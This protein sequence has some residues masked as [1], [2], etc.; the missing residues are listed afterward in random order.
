MSDR[1]IDESTPAGG[2]WRTTGPSSE[3]PAEPAP[4]DPE[5]A[6]S[7]SELWRTVGTRDTASWQRVSEREQQPEPE[8][9]AEAEPRP[10]AAGIWRRPDGST[11]APVAEEPET[12]AAEAAQAE[13]ETDEAAEAVDEE[14]PAGVL[15]FEQDEDDED[16][17]SFSMS[18]LVALA[19]LADAA[20][21]VP[22]EDAPPPKPDE[23]MGLDPAEYARQQME[24][25]RGGVTVEEPP[26][27]AEAE[28]EAEAPAE[29]AAPAVP[30]TPEEQKLAA[31]FR[32]AEDNIRALR[33][34]YRNGQITKEE[35]QAAL[36][37][38]MV[39]DEAE[40]VWWMMGVE[41]DQWYRYEDDGWVLATPAVLAKQQ[42]GAAQLED[43]STIPSSPITDDFEAMPLPRQVPVTDLDA[44]MPNTQGLFLDP[45]SQPT[46]AAQPADVTM[47]IGA[48]SPTVPSAGA[49]PTIP[50]VYGQPAVVTPPGPDAPSFDEA[51]QAQ[52]SRT[53]R[54][55]LIAAA[56]GFG[57]LMLLGACG[58]VLTITFY[59]S[60]VGPFQSQIS[61]LAN[62]QPSSQTARI[63]ADD[64]TLI[65]ELV[66][67]DGGSRQPVEL[68]DI[69]PYMVHAT[70]SAEDPLFF[71]N[72]GC[73]AISLFGTFVNNVFG[74]I[75]AGTSIE[76]Q[77]A[78]GLVIQSSGDT[79]VNPM[80]DRAVACE[81]NQQFTKP[82]LLNLY[83]NEVYFGNRT[84]GV[85]AASD[86]YFQQDADIL[87]I[88]Q[89]ALLAGMIDAPAA[90][91]P[92]VN[93]EASFNRM[94]AVLNQM[95][96]V[97]CIN[98]RYPPYNG[99]PFCIAQSDL[100][101]GQTSL[102]KARVEA[103]SYAPREQRSL[104][105]QFVN[106]V[107]SVIEQYYGATEI[108]QR[109]FQIYTTLNPSLQNAAQQALTRAVAGAQ[110]AG[111][112]TG[113]V[114]VTDPRSGAVLAM[115]GSPDFNNTS[116][117][118]QVNQVFTW[119][120]AGGAIMPVT[121]TAA[122]EGLTV[123]NSFQYMTAA[124]ILWDVPT[125]YPTAPPFTPVNNNGQF[126][127]PV[128]VRFALAN[129]HN[130]AAT[131]ALAFTGLER[132]V[133][134]AQRMGL[135]FLPDAQ[136]G[137]PSALG[138][139]EVRLFDMQQAYATLANGGV[140]VTQFPITRITDSS[141]AAVALPAIAPP[142]TTVQ[143]Q[144]AFLVQNILA[145]NE[146]RA[147]T[148]GLNSPLNIPE[149]GGRVAALAGTSEGSRD[150][151]TLGFTGNRV[152]GVWMGSVNSTP[153]GVSAITAAAPVW[154]TVMRTALNSAPPPQFTNPGG[155]VQAQVCSATG[156][157][158]DP[159][160]PYPC[161]GT[162]TEIF[163]QTMPPPPAQQSFIQSVPIDS[164]N[165]LRANQ[166]CQDN[167][168]TRT[169]L[170]TD[171]PTA[172]PWISSPA[173]AGFA[174]SVGLQPPN[175]VA[176]GG[177][178]TASTQNPVIAISSPST[179]QTVSGVVQVTGQA[180]A[181]N[182]NRYQL[183]VAPANTGSF[184][185]VFGPVGTQVQNGTLG[186]WD[187]SAVPNGNYDLRLTMFSSTGGTASR[188]TTVQVNNVPPTAQPTPPP[189]IEPSPLPPIEVLPMPTLPIV[190]LGPT[191]TIVFGP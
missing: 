31:D 172:G 150:L 119:Q 64:G 184:G 65:A 83:L 84:Y 139:N 24:R 124:T 8:A 116:I 17:D 118:G 99:Q 92:V 73:S 117:D 123:G 182:F 21:A 3:P 55:V 1:P 104:Y 28:A 166:F 45:S 67:A 121:Y 109:G 56:I 7:S 77:I 157:V 162:R 100:T 164:W 53:T 57:M 12:G 80:R 14:A 89:S 6:Q 148:F 189:I 91:D 33:E 22:I 114:L 20:P 72:P 30:L 51:V 130:V 141:G 2:G 169:V 106:Y 50:G 128:P 95:A 81:L 36:K 82:E 160:Q 167:V 151:W 177:E 161:P 191:P 138:T 171:D 69:S 142:S 159:A 190:P 41:S 132:W 76:E 62:F 42:A 174:A 4:P 75:E 85:Q 63:Y 186:Q 97:G 105:P 187:T 90:F 38:E 136:F 168:F 68:A 35:L 25:L 145:D 37:Q 153:T 144:I 156:A 101:S 94:N 158:F 71:E 113:A 135:R 27:Q 39:F 52:R 149:F 126:N 48:G 19:S 46:L 10:E 29:T 79:S 98:L 181:A 78:R 13:T 137:L 175:T 107:Q 134:T 188:T 93:R 131:K 127:G 34:Q 66:G 173:G 54:N 86:F 110:T 44:T 5:P 143:P 26:A 129:T 32:T 125:T 23:H 170:V 165:M 115:V 146:A 111:V 103:A 61:G 70:L 133:E 179:G 178:C 9:V 140:R 60:L 59:N 43:G 183:E 180:S 58:L 49:V 154:N 120:L 152:V 88:A 147:A 122:L 185:I 15:P 112:N 163:A 16:D 74:G 18:E 102:D 176:P 155:M 108:Y 96:A 11:L 47:P 87:N 40:D